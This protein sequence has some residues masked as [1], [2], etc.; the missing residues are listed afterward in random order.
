MA[1]PAKKAQPKASLYAWEGTDR[2]GSRITGETRATNVALVRAELRR[3]GINPLKVRK[4]TTSFLTSRKRKIKSADIAVFSRQLATMMSAGV[5]MVQAFEI[6]GRG[7]ENPSM[8]DLILSV[9]SDVEGGTALADALKKHPLHFDDLFCNLVKAGEHAGVLETL[10]HK[11]A[12]YKE[13]TESI[14]G[15]IKK[16]LF[17]PAAVVLVAIIVTAIIMIFVIPQFEQLFRGFGADLPVFTR[18][19]INIAHVVQNWWWAML[20]G[21]I[22][23]GYILIGTWKRSRKFRHTVDRILLKIPIIGPIMNK[24]AIARFARTLSTMSSAGVPLVEALESVSGATGNVVYSEA[25][26]RMREDVATGQ[27]LQLAMRQR[28]I[29]PN[30]VIQMVS[31]GEESGSLDDMLSKVADFFE[32]QVDNAVDALSSLLEPLI[33]VILGTLI[34]G[35]V[36]AMYLPIFKMGSAVLG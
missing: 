35:L 33:M 16:A 21:A 22:L 26:L 14:K 8:Q 4:K 20:G 1:P 24:A 3:Q 12:L 30:M 28:H 9:K 10:L 32:E 5:P 25:V 2:K 23:S 7:H 36:V 15:K 34:G 17:Y 18:V 13:K 31:I 11:I 27:S 29:F 6:V 19:V